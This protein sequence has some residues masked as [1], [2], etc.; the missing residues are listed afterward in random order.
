HSKYNWFA[1]E[2]VLSSD[3]VHANTKAYFI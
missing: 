1:K 2:S 3:D